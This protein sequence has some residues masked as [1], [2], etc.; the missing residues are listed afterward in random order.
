VRRVLLLSLLALLALPAPASAAAPKPRALAS[1][2]A[3]TTALVKAARKI[4]ACRTKTLD[5][6]ACDNPLPPARGVVIAATTQ[7][8]Y[9]LE[10]RSKQGRR[11]TLER[12]TGGELLSTC[13]P[14]GQGACGKA[15][16]WKPKPRPVMSPGP[17]Q[18][19]VAHEREVVLHLNALVAELERCRAQRGTFEGCDSDL[20]V[21]SARSWPGLPFGVELVLAGPGTNSQL[22]AQAKSGTWFQHY[23]TP[24]GTSERNCLKFSYAMVSPC[25]D[26][27]W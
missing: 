17:G 1:D 3:A 27:R 12:G 25:V 7:Y 16:T 2:A 6:T 8:V 5:Y 4:E 20:A 14:A 11:F 26:G 15:G 23:W 9:V 18:E 13:T 19:W 22:Q 10:A 24:D 21:A